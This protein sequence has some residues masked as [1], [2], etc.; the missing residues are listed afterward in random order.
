MNGY[1][2]TN[3]KGRPD[4]SLAEVLRP[5]GL[6]LEEL[7]V[8]GDHDALARLLKERDPGLVFIPPLWDDLFCVKLLNSILTLDT[9]FEP[10]IIGAAPIIP[11]LVAAF[12]AG[13]AGFVE[14]P[15]N[16]DLFRQ[17]FYRAKQRLDARIETMQN[18][19]RLKEYET[20]SAPTIFSQQIVERDQLLARAFMDLIKGKGPIVN[21]NVRLMLISSSSAQQASFSS[22]LKGVGID[23]TTAGSMKEAL[24][25][26]GDGH[27]FPIVIS[28]NLLPDG[29]AITLVNAMRKTVK[30]AMPRFIV[31]TASPDKAA[32]LLKPETHIDDIIVKPRSG[33]RM[34]SILPAIIS[35][36][37]QVRW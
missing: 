22:F 36:I 31:L 23:V 18:L 13:L 1:I 3:G 19:R 4:P 24:K 34:E 5:Y 6:P 11:N 2:V 37:Y 33:E 21:Q 10:V 30:E 14:I 15:I 29:D 17:V 9:P 27:H 12:N 20:G 7:D 35:G 28:D 25:I 26:L 32:E 16:A 8:A